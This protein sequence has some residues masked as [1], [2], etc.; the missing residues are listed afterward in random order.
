MG[1]KRK[2]KQNTLVINRQKGNKNKTERI[3]TIE[4]KELKENKIKYIKQQNL[5]KIKE[6]K[7]NENK[8]WQWKKQRFRCKQTDAMIDKD[9]E[10]KNWENW[11]ES[12]EI[13][14][15]VTKFN[16]SSQK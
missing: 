1:I 10:K 8:D 4:N 12:Q 9:D 2:K 15:L 14:K 13:P 6:K 11:K 7:I 5:R 3:K 16:R